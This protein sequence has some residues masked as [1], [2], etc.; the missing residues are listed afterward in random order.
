MHRDIVPDVPPSF[1]NIGSSPV[2]AVQ[3]L[4]KRY[5]NSSEI[6]ILTVQGHPEFTADIV[7]AIID[8]R[9]KSGAMD[10]NTV[11]DGRRRAIIEHDG[12]GAIVRAMWR[13]L[14]VNAPA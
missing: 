6:H 11:K 5:P 2:C 9:E 7:Q 10:E 13:V 1:E 14:G 8:V 12:I 4:V 3:G